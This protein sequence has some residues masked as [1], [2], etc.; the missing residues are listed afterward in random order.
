MRGYWNNAVE[1]ALAFDTEGWLHTGDVGVLDED[2]FL[3][4]VDRLKDLI[5][6]SGFNVYPNEIE[7]YVCTHPSIRDACVIAG[8]SELAPSIQLFVV[9]TDAALTSTD[10]LEYC[11]R[12]LAPY[13]VPR[14]VE[15]RT[16]LPK[17][18]LGKVLRRQLRPA[19]I[20][21]DM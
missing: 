7:D 8:G 4:I 9:S 11:R 18:A 10:V 1:T 15:F 6:I 12:G 3:R 2:G 21:P 13:K 17:S 16:T 20:T 5:V 19:V 14:V